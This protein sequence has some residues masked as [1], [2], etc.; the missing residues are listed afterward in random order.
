MSEQKISASFGAC[1]TLLCNSL[2]FSLD[3]THVLWK[4]IVGYEISNGPYE[5]HKNQLKNASFAILLSKCGTTSIGSVVDD[6]FF[7]CSFYGR[8]NPF[9]FDLNRVKNSLLRTINNWQ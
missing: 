6:D 9:I 7:L 8:H 1:I 4:R 5:N 2:A 3:A